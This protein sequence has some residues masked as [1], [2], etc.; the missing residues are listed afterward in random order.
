MLLT[1]GSGDVIEYYLS[2]LDC[3]GALDRR[4]VVVVIL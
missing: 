4:T 2:M 1:W 3:I